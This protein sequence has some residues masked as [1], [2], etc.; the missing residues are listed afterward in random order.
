MANKK[1]NVNITFVEPDI[2]QEENERRFEEVKRVLGKIVLDM[3][4]HGVTLD[5]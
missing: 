5:N 1:V 3:R 2:T 4:K